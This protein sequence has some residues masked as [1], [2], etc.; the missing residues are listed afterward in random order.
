MSLADT[1]YDSVTSMLA[2]AREKNREV[3]KTIAPLVGKSIAE[4]G[5]L[6]T[7]GSGHS[8]LI[9]REIIGRAGGLMPATELIDP[10]FGFSE[11]VVGY[12]TRLVERYDR[13]YQLK[14][15]E[16]IIVVSN[17]GKN[18]SPIEVAL[19]ARAKGLTVIG[20]TSM[21]ISTTS[22]TVHPGGQN[23]HAVADY[24]LDNLSIAGDAITEVAPGRFAGPTST[25]SGVMLVNLL[26][27]EVLEWLKANGHPLPLVTSQNIPEGREAN[28]ALARQY[29]TRLSH[30][31]G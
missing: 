28:L 14:P 7:F 4:G 5:V 31:I 18:S 30:M 12:G 19:Y 22:E 1:Y 10:G 8:G 21:G 24:T 26:N 15:G 17:S 2:Q 3:L 29:G 23:L 11:N 6:H 16:S 25:I 27:L 20:I 9:S 13:H